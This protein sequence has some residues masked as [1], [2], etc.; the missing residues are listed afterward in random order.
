MTGDG[1]RGIRRPRGL[2]SVPA[3]FLQD[4]RAPAAVTRKVPSFLPE[5]PALGGEWRK[6]AILGKGSLKE[7]ALGSQGRSARLQSTDC[8]GR[9]TSRE[10]PR[11]GPC[12]SELRA[13]W[14]GGHGLKR[15]EK[16]QKGLGRRRVPGPQVTRAEEVSGGAWGRRGG[17]SLKLRPRG[18]EGES[19]RKVRRGP[20]GH[21]AQ[22]G[23]WRKWGPGLCWSG[24]RHETGGI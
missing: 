3:P 6:S 17:V 7:E 2:S 1:E 8:P 11:L 14:G 19:H 13:Y 9:E 15:C 4:V 20:G 16:F 21:Q 24:R 23:L 10:Q 12:S 5:T 18:G 22:S